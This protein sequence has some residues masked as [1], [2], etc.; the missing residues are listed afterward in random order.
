[1]PWRIGLF[2][3]PLFF[4][5]CLPPVIAHPIPRSNHD[6]KIQVLVTHDPYPSEIVRLVC[7]AIGSAGIVP[8][9]PCICPSSAANAQVSKP[10]PMRIEVLYRLEVDE[11]T[12]VQ[13]DMAPFADQVDFSKYRGKADEFYTE[14]CRLYAPIFAANLQVKLDGRGYKFHP[15][16]QMHTLKDEKGQ[17]LGHLRCDFFLEAVVPISPGD[18][19][20]LKVRDGTYELQTGQIATGLDVDPFW[21]LI[22]KIEAAE[23]LKLLP[24]AE[25]LPGD[26]EKLRTVTA[27]FRSSLPLL[28]IEVDEL[29]FAAPEAPITSNPPKVSLPPQPITDCRPDE[30]HNSGLLSLFLQ[31]D[32]GVWLLLL[33]STVFGAA[34]AV[35]PGH[36]KT[37]V[38]A[39]LV[40]ERGTA[41]HALFLGCVTTLTHTG[42]VLVIAAVFFFLPEAR[43]VETRRAIQF[44]LGMGM[45]VAITGL[46]FWLLLRRL[47]GKVDHIHLGGHGHHH[48]H[49]GHGHH[50]HHH[51]Y[52]DHDH[53]KHGNIITRQEGR[54][55]VGWWGLITLGVTGGLIPCWD[56]VFLLLYSIG[57]NQFWLALPMLLA[58]SAGLA[59]VLVALG[60][61]V[62]WARRFTGKLWR[63]DPLIRAL[64][65]LSAVV[66]VGMGFWLCYES[67]YGG[68]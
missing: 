20:T 50:H 42:V 29:S 4:V 6:R 59:A 1:M 64:P 41:L 53:D 28:L 43:D 24:E 54:K 8:V 22:E 47:T 44:T 25:R 66:I 52:A 55:R 51:H 12:V 62:V 18:L 45:G 63:F 13:G 26:E 58:F 34:H 17:A 37:L 2:V 56:A 49:H 60:L 16:R 31:S 5:W 39:Y 19:H 67:L 40:G 33:I 48:H 3:V 9:L 15:V 61:S 68:H 65:I 11:L 21:E 27:R 46:G 35:T 14:F 10:I 32:G 36:G 30:G 7:S 38:A 23:T 57:S